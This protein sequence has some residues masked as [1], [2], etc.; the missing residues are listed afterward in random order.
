MNNEESFVNKFVNERASIREYN[1]PLYTEPDD[2]FLETE[3]FNLGRTYI[4]DRLI[5]M[6]AS[7]MNPQAMYGSATRISS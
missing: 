4:G 5:R 2:T 3:K 6:N 7:L 1:Q